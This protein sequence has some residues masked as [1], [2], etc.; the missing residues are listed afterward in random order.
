MP[1]ALTKWKWM[2]LANTKDLSFGYA[3]KTFVTQ[4]ELMV[5]TNMPRFFRAGD[6]MLLP[7]KISNLSSTDLNGTVHLEWLDASSNQNM[8][9]VLGNR[10]TSQPFNV[11]ASQTSIVFFQTIVPTH[12]S[13]PLLYRV[14]ANADIKGADYS[15]GEEN[16]IPVL[17]K[18]MLI[19]E[20]LPLNMAGR[21]E[22]HFTFD[23]LLKSGTSSS[24]Q[25]QS[26]T[27]EFTTN[28]AWY[29]VQSLPYLM[30]FPYECAEQTFNRFYANALASHMVQIS[31]AMQAVLEK[32]KNTD[33]AALLSNLQK[34]EELK[35]VILQETPW[36]LHAQ[37][38]T[39]QKKNLA[40]LFDMIRMR[41]ALK[42]A[43]GKLEQM[44]SETGAFAWFKGGRDDRYIT[45][46]V[47][48]GIG[49]L[50]K[51][52]A[53]PPEL[54]L[55]LN[56][57]TGSA[58]AYLDK[59]I[60]SDFDTRNKFPSDQSLGSIQIQ[61][62]YMRS[63]FPEIKIPDVISGAFDYYKSQATEKWMKQS[64]YMQAMISL[65]L[66]RAG[67]SK[68]ANDILASL[69][70]NATQTAA[71]GMYWKSV[72]NGYY[73][74]DAPVETQSLLIETFQEMKAD[75]KI[76]D[77][78]KYWLLEQKHTSH[79]PTTKA[80]ADAC[81][82]LL[83]DGSDWLG[84]NQA[85]SIQLGSYQ[86]DSENEKTEA[87]TGYF[88]KQ[89][90][91][92]Q[93]KPEMGNIDVHVKNIQP[94]SVNG[95]RSTVN[96]IQS[97]ANRQLPTAN[98]SWGSIYWQYFEDL[99]KITA[100]QTPLSITKNLFIERN[101]DKGPLLEAVSERNVLEPGDKLIMRIIVK[102]DR[103]LEYV[104]L[105]DMRAAC[106]EPVN[107]LSEYKWQDGIG[108]Y[109]TTKDASTSFFFDKL[110]KGTYVFEYPVFVTTA[111]NYSNG[112]SEL[113]C[114]YAPEF[115]AHSEGIRIRVE[116]K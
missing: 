50:K 101:S 76:I 85:V 61:Y 109:E 100:A 73:W 15:D 42:S 20:S 89:I 102:T 66:N 62:L 88:K 115:A 44:Q 9:T 56:K 111:G 60:K 97:S 70:E 33:T 31:P 4:K 103:D 71:T 58:I 95:Q 21:E 24:L 113:E 43:L 78:M 39:Q 34:N 69:Q 57:I 6:T 22:Q 90:P 54:M 49:K 19:T 107:V 96:D 91:G 93:I 87:G 18:Q 2:I 3:E 48:S 38:E 8:D 16:I 26:L 35:S 106:L 46:Y 14:I 67:N 53:I 105:K 5:Q 112:V 17:S 64:V 51:L 108:Y 25:N 40:L 45:Q 83:M 79:W 114:M 59:E 11:N 27:V 52:N 63:F 37:S 28:P 41:G 32:W 116:S 7:V 81:Y 10:K 110:P 75:K 29:A 36:V 99:D 94:L 77:Q 47:I 98:P 72:S 84:N 86:L 68:I 1:D 13:Q 104:H 82:A 23:K 12:F 74:Q 80:T 92:D 65:F 55:Q 30:E